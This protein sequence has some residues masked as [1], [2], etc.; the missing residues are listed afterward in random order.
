MFVGPSDPAVATLVTHFKAVVK[1]IVDS[2]WKHLP[3]QWLTA[4][5]DHEDDDQIKRK[6]KKNEKKKKEKPVMLR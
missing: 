1:D 6:H 4:V 3:A 2:K 5:P